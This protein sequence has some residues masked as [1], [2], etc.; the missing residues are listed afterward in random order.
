[1][2]MLRR[3][4]DRRSAGV[5]RRRAASRGA[6]VSDVARDAGRLL[7]F[8]ACWSWPLR[9]L[10][11]LGAAGFARRRFDR[12]PRPSVWR[13]FALLRRRGLGVVG[14][15]RIGGLAGA[16]SAAAG[17]FCG[18]GGV[19]RAPADRRALPARRLRGRPGRRR[20]HR[21]PEPD[22]RRPASG[23]GTG[24]ATGAGTVAVTACGRDGD[25]RRRRLRRCRRRLSGRDRRSS[26]SSVGSA[27]PSGTTTAAS[28]SDRE[29][30]GARTV[31]SGATAAS[32]GWLRD[33]ART[34]GHP[35]PAACRGRPR[36]CR[37]SFS[38]GCVR[39]LR[40]IAG[41]RVSVARTA[42]SADGFVA[43]GARVAA[44][45]GRGR[46]SRGSLA[47]RRARRLRRC[48]AGLER[49]A[50]ASRRAPGDREPA[51]DAWAAGRPDPTRL[52]ARQ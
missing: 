30:L 23:V 2:R 6:G 48:R 40:V 31:A 10:V 36:A 35:W 3:R 20:R 17:C 37:N 19:R 7:A 51:Q 43:L 44:A 38:A 49:I 41:A 22:A 9:R 47:A 12:R 14:L 21:P 52:S 46:R 13:A 26:A 45:L 50:S 24:V 39:T 5:G 15:R 28:A 34:I 1:M 29:L 32:L 25:R 8:G 18:S 33:R 27:S 16:A 42:S 11:L 4:L